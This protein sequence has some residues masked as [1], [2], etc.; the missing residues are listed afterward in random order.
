MEIG[1]LV[2]LLD[3]RVGTVVFH[4]LT[5]YGIKW[6]VH[7]PPL[8]DFEGTSGDMVRLPDDHPAKSPDWPWHVDAMLR[9]PELTESLGVECVGEDYE[10]VD[11]DD[12]L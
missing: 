7:H 11:E 1:T 3:R 9:D 2:R 4:G 8:E 10:I 5:G 12:V 6:G